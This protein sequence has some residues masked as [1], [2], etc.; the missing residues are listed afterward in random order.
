[1]VQFSEKVIIASACV[2]EQAVLLEL[3]TFQSQPY[4]QASRQMF[5]P[6]VRGVLLGL[7][8]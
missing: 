3:F 2:L 5:L 1:M 4:N 6:G 7:H 8:Q